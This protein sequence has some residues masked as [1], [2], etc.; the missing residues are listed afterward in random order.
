MSK[1]LPQ[2]SIPGLIIAYRFDDYVNRKKA[3]ER[4]TK[5]ASPDSFRDDYDVPMSEVT[6]KDLYQAQS[7]WDR[8]GLL[9]L[10]V[11]RRVELCTA[12]AKLVTKLSSSL[13][14]SYFHDYW[15]MVSQNPDIV[16]YSST[17]Y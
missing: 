16:N 12:L 14:G 5:Q 17:D 4:N 9:R 8:E 7:L 11:D 3:S 6:E 1:S 10:D 15:R 13:K 2:L